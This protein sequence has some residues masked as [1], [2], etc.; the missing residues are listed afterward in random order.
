MVAGDGGATDSDNEPLG[1]LDA[2]SLGQLNDSFR[3]REARE[4]LGFYFDSRFSAPLKTALLV[5]FLPLFAFALLPSVLRL[6]WK[7]ITGGK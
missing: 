3:R 6:A 2:V 7:W 4:E 1:Q 5:A